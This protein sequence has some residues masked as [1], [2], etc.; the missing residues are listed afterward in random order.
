MIFASYS[1]FD[2]LRLH[3]QINQNRRSKI[4]IQSVMVGGGGEGGGSHYPTRQGSQG[5]PLQPDKSSQ[6][7][8]PTTIP[9]WGTPQTTR[10]IRQTPD[11]I[12]KISEI[13]PKI[14]FLG[15]FSTLM[16]HR[17]VQALWTHHTVLNEVTTS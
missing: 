12:Q 16:S 17:N 4:F 8:S 3:N 2:E 11:N 5:D 14:E 15:S 1:H 7:G 13:F 9:D 6:S 10:K